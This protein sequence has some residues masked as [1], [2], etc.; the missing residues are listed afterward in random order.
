L[1]LTGTIDEVETSLSA[2]YENQASLLHFLSQ[3]GLPRPAALDLAASFAINA[4]LKRALESDPIDAVQVRSWL[5]LAQA[6]QVSLD[7]PLL[8]YLADKRMKSSMVTLHSDPNEP[9]LLEDALL[10][11]RTLREL[12]FDLNLWQAQNLWYDAFRHIR[13]QSPADEVF[14]KWK[15]L[16]RQLHISVED[17]V[18]EEGN[19]NGLH[20]AAKIAE[21]SSRAS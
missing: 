6:D 4:G 8:S 16:G 7:K 3:S 17:I 12:P 19:G 10:I 18:A 13:D 5:D 2:I 1:L 14:E 11:A 9:Y 15:E 20:E 21:G